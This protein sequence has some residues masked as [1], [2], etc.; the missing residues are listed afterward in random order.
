MPVAGLYF[1]LAKVEIGVPASGL[2][3]IAAAVLYWS[4]RADACVLG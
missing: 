2:Y 3:A 1:D 4:R